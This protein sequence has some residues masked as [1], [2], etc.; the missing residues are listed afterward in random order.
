MGPFTRDYQL[1]VVSFSL[2]EV[3]DDSGGNV[4]Q[5]SPS[6]CVE[7]AEEC[8]VCGIHVL[9]VLGQDV[10]PNAFGLQPVVACACQS[11]I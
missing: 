3:F 6:P 9:R 4:S 2:F 7:A 8:E 10:P 5:A 11:S 1:P